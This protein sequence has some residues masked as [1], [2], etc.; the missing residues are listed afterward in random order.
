MTLSVTSKVFLSEIPM[1]LI[2]LKRGVTKRYLTKIVVE[3]RTIKSKVGLL[4][5]LLRWLRADRGES[6]TV[7]LRSLRKKRKV[8]RRT[9]PRGIVWFFRIAKS[10]IFDS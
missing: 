8:V 5:V 2:K 4:L 1:L 3:R 6:S 10:S 7:W 9:G